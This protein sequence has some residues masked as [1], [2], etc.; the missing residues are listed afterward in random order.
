MA[1]SDFPFAPRVHRR[2]RADAGAVPAD[3]AGRALRCIRKASLHEGIC[4][5]G[6]KPTFHPKQSKPSL[7]VHIFDFHEDLYEEILG[8][9][10]ISYIRQEKKFNSI[11]ELKTQI[12]LDILQAKVKLFT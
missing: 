5:L 1:G 7:E 9:Q 2:Q 8:I 11:D 12:E 10:F 4:N 6:K 3:Q